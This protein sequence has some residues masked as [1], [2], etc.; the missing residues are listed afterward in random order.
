MD[1]FNNSDYLPSKDSTGS[2]DCAVGIATGM[3]STAGVLYQPG[4]NSLSD[5]ET[6]SGGPQISYAMGAEG[7]I[8]HHSPSYCVEVKNCA[9]RHL[10]PHTSS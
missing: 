5:V 8:P 6:G 3:G 4:A 1:A 9:A 10:L 2:Q 7:L